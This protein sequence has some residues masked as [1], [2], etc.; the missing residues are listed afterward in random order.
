MKAIILV[1]VSA[2][3]KSTR[4]RLLCREGYVALDRDDIRFSMTK[5][6]SWAEYNFDHKLENII[7]DVHKVMAEKAAAQGRD[8]VI[9]E[10]NL[11][12]KT[13]RRWENRL[14]NLGYDVIMVP[15][16]ITLEEAVDRDSKRE[17]SVGRKVIES[18]WSNW[19]DFLHE[20]GQEDRL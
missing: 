16:H 3:G 9:A 12:P 13:R 5:A 14:E 6:Q 17:Y 8:V 18:Q 20:I 4:A 7:N 1:G 15:M 10:T 11:N 2:S 19:I